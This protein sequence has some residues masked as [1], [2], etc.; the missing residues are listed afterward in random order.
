[1]TKRVVV[2]G[3]TSQIGDFLLPLLCKQGF[4]VVA[5][6]RS[7]QEPANGGSGS[8]GTAIEWVRRD[9]HSAADF[10][11]VMRADVLIHLAPLALLVPL[12]PYAASGGIR[13]IIAF[14]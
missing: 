6:S 11:D 4:H 14:G 13:R 2:T 8:T 7:P 5:I 10:A 12:L 9:I 3:A 1:M